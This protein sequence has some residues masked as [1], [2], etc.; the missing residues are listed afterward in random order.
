MR[1]QVADIVAIAVC[2]LERRR[3]TTHDEDDDLRC[4]EDICARFGELSESDRK[5]LIEAF[6]RMNAGEL[7]E[8]MG[9]LDN[10]E[11]R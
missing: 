9:L 3:N 11:G 10:G 4:L 2:Y 8:G 1:P 5:D 7:A 6:Y